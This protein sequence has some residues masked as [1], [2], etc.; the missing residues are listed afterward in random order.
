MT[1]SLSIT[2]PA[3]IKA[4]PSADDLV[5]VAFSTDSAPSFAAR[6][7]FFIFYKRY[8]A[9]NFASTATFWTLN[10]VHSPPLSG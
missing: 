2:T 5:A 4:A 7:R 6:A 8:D 9:G 1:S 10:F 3:H